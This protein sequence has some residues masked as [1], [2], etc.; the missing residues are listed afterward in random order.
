MKF[1]NTRPKKIIFW[2]VAPV[3]I[4]LAV[5]I[6]CISPVARYLVEKYDVKY[7]NREITMDLPYINVFT[8]KVYLRNVKVYEEKSDS[9][10]FSASGIGANL[11]MFKL[12]SKT[13]EV[14]SFTLHDPMIRFIQRDSVTFN[15]AD[16]IKKFASKDTAKPKVRK[17]PVHFNFYDL[18]IK[19]GTFYYVER[20]INVF[21][22]VKKVNIETI[23]KRW[24]QDTIPINFAFES[25][26]GPGTMKGRLT[27]NTGNSNYA[28]HLNVKDFQLAALEQYVMSF[29]NYGK[30]R[31]VLDADITGA[32]NIKN[33]QSLNLKGQ[34][35]LADLHF[36]KDTAEDYASFKKLTLAIKQLAPAGKKY[37]LDSIS[38]VKPYF[39]YERYDHLDNLQNM[40]GKGGNNVNSARQHRNVNILFQ[41]A[42]YIAALARNFFRSDFNV[43]RLAIYN[44]HF[45]YNDYALAEK[46]STAVDPLTL[47]ADS[48]VRSDRW[49]NLNL[50]TGLKPYG[51]VK[52]RLSINPKDSSDFDVD[53]HIQKIP[54]A[55][56]NPYL[57]SFTSFPLDRGT[58]EMTG[59]WRVR[60]GVIKSSNRIT[61]IDARVNNRQ[62]RNGARWIPLRVAMFFVRDRGNV[63][64]YD[65]PVKGDLRNPKFK[66]WGA[67][68]KALSNLFIKPVTTVYRTEVRST[69]NEIEN[70]L[71]VRWDK[72]RSVLESDQEEFVEK[73]AS[74]LKHNKQVAITIS[75][76]MY[77]EKE[78]EYILFFEAKKQFYLATHHLHAK[79]L[80]AGDST[81]IDHISIKDSLFVYYLNKHAGRGLL[82][83]VQDKCGR[84]VS[85]QLVTDR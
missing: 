71:Q 53:Y 78:K 8:G 51:D 38:L 56:F 13:Y 30:F 5:T 85:R 55:M 45:K 37:F 50:R 21:Y 3:V 54:M 27:I 6:I 44:A 57:I 15:F 39:K 2:I 28:F 62:K 22:Y 33:R 41:I 17:P 16:I 14:S 48:I 32:A 58:F 43:R 4:L 59:K 73:I 46:F 80:K 65:I 1:L 24:D 79:E 7:T 68:F 82:F 81:D 77:E 26:T 36:G 75:P 84:I 34:L 29:A 60:D 31:A 66:I 49:V 18:S 11:E 12:L 35:S 72:R 20:S 64:D 83:T 10:F 52:F 9:V 69:E 40:F 74:F 61:M 67:I 47:I 25:G 63:I 70:S 76:L 23:G 42:D 19:N